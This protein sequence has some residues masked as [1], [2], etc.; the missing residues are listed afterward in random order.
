MKSLKAS[1]DYHSYGGAPFL[2][3]KKIVVKGHGSTNEVS[4]AAS[5]DMIISLH[6]NRVLE[7]I[8]KSISGAAEPKADVVQ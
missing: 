5:V 2:G 6:E 4:A 3:V 1:M 8:E 7:T